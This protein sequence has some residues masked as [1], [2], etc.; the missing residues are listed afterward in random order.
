MSKIVSK[1]KILF[2]NNSESGKLLQKLSYIFVAQEA[3]PSGQIFQRGLVFCG[4]Y[5]PTLSGGL[6]V[7]TKVYLP[8]LSG[9]LQVTTEVYLPTLSG[10]L[11][12][13]TGVYLPTLPGGLQV[14]TRVYLPPSQENF[15]HGGHQIY[16]LAIP[17]R[18][19]N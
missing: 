1:K 19:E 13:T 3:D 12:V 15:S 9:G 4:V 14:I 10:G 2:F 6:Q 11:Q 18:Q 8:S 5:L 7:T 16:S 17:E